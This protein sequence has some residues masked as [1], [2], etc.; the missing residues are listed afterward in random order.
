MRTPSCGTSTLC[1]AY[2]GGNPDP[3]IEVGSYYSTFEFGIVLVLFLI[4]G[5]YDKKK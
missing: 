2:R 3:N 5:F 1:V 4:G